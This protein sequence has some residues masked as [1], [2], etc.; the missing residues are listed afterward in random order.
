MSKAA[1]ADFD[2]RKID[3]L[4]ASVDQ[5]HGPGA[6]VG[7]AIDGAPVYRK[8]F[9]LADMQ[10]P[11]VLGTSTRMRIGSTTKHFVALAFMLLCEQG[12]AD[13]DEQIGKYVPEVHESTARASMRRLLAHTSGVRDVYQI[14]MFTSGLGRVVTG[15]ELLD[16]YRTI[17][18]VDFPSGR[19]WSYNNGGYLLVSAAIERITGQSL[20]EVLRR[21]IFEPVGMYD[22]C[23]RRWDTDYLANSAALHMVDPNGGFTRQTLGMELT[24]AGGVVSTMDDMLRWLR[25][26]DAPLIGSAETWRLI[27]RP[28]EL[29]NRSH[30]A[31]GLGLVVDGYRGLD[32]LCHPG[33]VMGG[34]SQMIKVPAA[35][36]DISIAVNRAD[37]LAAD[38]ANRIIDLCVDGLETSPA[39][40]GE[41]ACGAYLSRRTGRVITVSQRDG[42]AFVCVD[43]GMPMPLVPAA[44]GA[45]AP[46]PVF[47]FVRQTF[48]PIE[49]GLRFTE[50][51][52]RD[53]YERMAPVQ[54]TPAL[55][56]GDYRCDGIGSRATV[57]KAGDDARLR[58][59]GRHGEAQYDLRPLSERIWAAQSRDSLSPMAGV[60]TFSAAGGAFELT[61]DRMKRIR[62]QRIK[63]VN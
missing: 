41:L 29:A 9:G 3:A 46:A 31:Y 25:H 8:G 37:V 16:H 32:T 5:C 62:F 21:R 58:I 60:V 44:G 61:A 63:A 26:M 43:A 7:I 53:D 2:E 48:A 20:E 51:G 55:P 57:F 17:E 4:F 23:L 40:V 36:L 47:S 27:K 18:D 34:N 35:G 19:S 30:S 10:L 33:G 38:L 24:G 59:R 14:S 11:V 13:L 28:Q 52:Q 56:E 22:T 54:G 12:R 50:F 15:A 49:G 39:P 42:S 6:A 45:W 1:I